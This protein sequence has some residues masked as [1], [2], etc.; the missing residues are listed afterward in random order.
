MCRE[1]LPQ[2]FRTEQ[3]YRDRVN[4]VLLNTENSKWAPEMLEYGVRGIPHFVFLDGTG[5]VQAA[6]VGRLPKEVLQG[7]VDALAERRPLPYARVRGE[8]TAL[9]QDPSAGV[10]RAPATGPRDHA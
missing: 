1:L 9:Q 5:A 10:M 6:A 2:T 4:F 8:V 7:D 3:E